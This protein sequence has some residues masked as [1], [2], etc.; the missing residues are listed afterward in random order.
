MKQTGR[1]PKRKTSEEEKCSYAIEIM[2]WE[3]PYFFSANMNR[4]LID[5]PFWEHM[6]FKIE[7]KVI[8][9][10]KLGGKSV[11]II[12]FG[13]RQ[14]VPILEEPNKYQRFD[15][16]SVVTLAIRGKKREFLGSIPFDV[17]GSI[18]SLLQ[19]GKFKFIVLYG[20]VLYRGRAAITSFHL[21]KNLGAKDLR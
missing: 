4:H 17:I 2:D 12:I 7:G 6:D 11:D 18:I 8:H 19:Y 10:K 1:N 14:L 15:P 5:G 3:V 21:Q 9:P 13:D 16:R 20:Q